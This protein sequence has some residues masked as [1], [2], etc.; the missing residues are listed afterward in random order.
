MLRLRQSRIDDRHILHLIEKELI[1][2]SHF[3]QSGQA[4]KKDVNARLKRGVTFVKSKTARSAPFGFVHLLIHGKLM[5][6]DMLAVH[7]KYQGKGYGKDLLHCAERYAK[8]QGCSEVKLLVDY[9]NVKALR[10]YEQMG[11]QTVRYMKETFCFELT[12]TL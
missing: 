12:K 1:P 5:Y 2:L 6:L 11:Y 10:F 7:Y 8:V 4:L 9:E 3:P